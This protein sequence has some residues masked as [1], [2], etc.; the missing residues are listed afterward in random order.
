MS[1]AYEQDT[2]YRFSLFAKNWIATSGIMNHC[3]RNQCFWVL[4]TLASYVPTLARAQGVDYFLIVQVEVS[5]DKTSVFTIQQ[6]Q[7]DKEG[8]ATYQTLVRQEIDY[9]DLKETWTFW[10]I[11][12]SS[13]A[14]DPACQTVVLL[15]EEY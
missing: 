10:A 14:Y 6:E 13:G 8:N 15:P 9:T 5:L 7:H 12:E 2:Y 3:Q 1:V 4:D 11:N